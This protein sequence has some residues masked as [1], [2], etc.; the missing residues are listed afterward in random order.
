M[1]QISLQGIESICL[2]AK[3]SAKPGINIVD[4]PP[5]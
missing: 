1:H 5:N 3:Q 4:T 2:K